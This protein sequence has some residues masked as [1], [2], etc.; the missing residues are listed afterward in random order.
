MF[1]QRSLRNIP[2]SLVFCHKPFSK[3]MKTVILL[4]ILFN[5]YLIK[6]MAFMVDLPGMKLN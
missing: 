4:S 1:V 2:N 3:S 6:K 5:T